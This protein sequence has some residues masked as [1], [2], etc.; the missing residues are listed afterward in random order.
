ML[1]RTLKTVAVAA[2]LIVAT[3]GTS[4]AATYAYIDHDTWLYE[5][6]NTS[7]DHVGYAHEGE[8]VKVL[9]TTSSWAKINDD[10]DIGWIKKSKLDWAPDFVDYDYPYGYGFGGGAGFCA[11]GKG[12]SLCFSIGY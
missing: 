11:N 3:A 9:A 1:T 6:K 12:G 4:M 8:K 2:A 7:S 10:G 5:H